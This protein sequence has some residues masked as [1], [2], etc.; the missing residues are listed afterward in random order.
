MMEY[1]PSREDVIAIRCGGRLERGELDTYMD[2]LEA[3]LAAR[4]KTHFFVEVVDFDGLDMTGLGDALKRSGTYFR[5]LDR[6]GRVGIV[7]DQSWIRWAAQI[8]SALLPHVSYETFDASERDRAL[9]WVEG[10]IP[11]PHRPAL[12]VIETDRPDVFAFEID[13]HLSKAE[14]DAATVLFAEALAGKDQVRVLGRIRRLGGFEPGGLLSSD[15]F[16]MKRGFLER[17]E[18]YALVGGPGWLRTTLNAL[19]PLFKAEIRHFGEDEEAAAWT[20]IGARP[21]SERTLVD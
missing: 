2:R 17:M 13:G 15:Y 16:A 18:R 4:P 6:I 3:S 10:E 9:A 21:V 14:L 19:A 7:A 12:K 1:L 5:N 20:W 8:E 11:L